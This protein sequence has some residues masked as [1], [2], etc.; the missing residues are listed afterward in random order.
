MVHI[1]S[2]QRVVIML[3]QI[4]WKCC[5]AKQ[6]CEELGF[7]RPQPSIYNLSRT[8]KCFGFHNRL[9]IGLPGMKKVRLVIVLDSEWCFA[10]AQ[11]IQR[12]FF[13]QSIETNK[14]LSLSKYLSSCL[15]KRSTVRLWEHLDPNIRMPTAGRGSDSAGRADVSKYDRQ[16][17]LCTSITNITN[18]IYT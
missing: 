1:Q 4:S 8:R 12:F 6:T 11:R 13:S 10:V 16:L 9:V 14:L 7:F 3:F 5:I 15:V 17:S 2:N 18:N